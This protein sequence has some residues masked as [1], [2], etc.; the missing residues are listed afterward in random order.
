MNKTL[1]ETN[2]ARVER[3]AHFLLRA[4]NKANHKYRLL[5]GGD[6]VLVAVSG[7]KDSMTL[8]DLLYRYRRMAP[9]RYEIMAAR[10][11][12]DWHCGRSVP[13]AWLAA[14]CRER[15]IAFYTPTIAL[16]E[17]IQTG[18]ASP[19]FRCTWNRRKA[20]FLL[21]DE[22]GCSKVALGH[23]ADDIAETTLMNLFYSGR[24]YRMAP[25]VRFF[26]GRLTVIR[27]LVL[28]EER[29]IVPYVQACGFPI[30]GEPCPAGERSRRTM[31]KRILRELE[32]ESRGV[33]RSIMRAAELHERALRRAERCE[34]EPK[35]SSTTSEPPPD[36]AP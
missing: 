16:R 8:L 22:L 3:L 12:S 31:I 11:L 28:I 9:E 23:H 2:A 30:D 21:A 34:E 10:V 36:W 26:D 14:W 4:V 1:V 27:P 15:N 7:G 6:R 17:E 35:C 20:L 29:D 18:E 5:E 32:H 24:L 19:C 25:K 33:K 13:E